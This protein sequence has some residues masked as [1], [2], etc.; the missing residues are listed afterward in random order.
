MAR[1]RRGS[2]KSKRNGGGDKTLSGGSTGPVLHNATDEVIR[3][4][5]VKIMKADNEKKEAKKA[6]DSKNGFYRQ[7]F[8]DAGKEGVSAQALSWYM[9]NRERDPAE[10]DK[11]TAERNRVA[12]VM[13]L[14]IS[15]QL[16]LLDDGQ[17]VAGAVDQQILRKQATGSDLSAYDQGKQAAL[18]GK[19]ISSNPFTEESDDW[20]DFEQGWGA[21]LRQRGQELSGE[22]TAH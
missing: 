12:R 13:N 2:G 5:A 18:E 16:G 11:E 1:G 21:G 6:Y 9:A 10:I 20:N 17:T 22:A 14:P 19:G 4:W 7:L 8:N 3:G 15:T